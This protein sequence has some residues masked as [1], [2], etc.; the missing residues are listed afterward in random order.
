[1]ASAAE[2]VVRDP[3]T[4]PRVTIP[5]PAHDQAAI[6][7]R[8]LIPNESIGVRLAELGF[9]GAS[10]IDTGQTFCFSRNNNAGH[11][12]DDRQ[13]S[14]CRASEGCL[15]SRQH[16]RVWAYQRIQRH[17]RGGDS[18]SGLGVILLGPP[19]CGES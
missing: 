4:P 1:M 9:V 2:Y 19:I 17:V 7:G 12:V 18:I 3:D 8:R 10:R 15:P 13:W 16:A 14:A 6:L 11:S 5:L